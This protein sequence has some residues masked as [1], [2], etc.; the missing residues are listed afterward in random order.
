[1]TEIRVQ[2]VDVPGL[3]ACTVGSDHWEELDRCPLCNNCL[4]STT[5]SSVL[6]PNG[7]GLSL[8]PKMSIC[9]E[10]QF[11]YLSRRPTEKWIDSFYASEWDQ[12]GQNIIPNVP[13][14]LKAY[15]ICK[16]DLGEESRVLEVGAGFGGM[17]LP[18]RDAG[19][20]IAA[21]EPSEH[22]AEHLKS[23]GVEVFK[24]IPTTGDYDL[25]FMH[26]ALEHV[27][28]AQETVRDIS[29][30]LRPGGLFFVAVPSLYQE[31]PIQASHYVPHLS[32]FTQHSLTL[33]L[34]ENGL[35]PLKGSFDMELWCIAQKREGG[36]AE[37]YDEN[38]T[39]RI[40][41]WALQG[42][43]SGPLTVSWTID[44]SEEVRYPSLSMVGH[45]NARGL[46]FKQD[47]L[48][49]LWLDCPEKPELPI[50]YIHENTNPVWVK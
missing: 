12:K 10:C 44:H 29:A 36:K 48:R 6:Q 28:D 45:L 39:D 23:Q 7:G 11:G 37:G 31:H 26:H 43:A 30:A 5:L 4:N 27:Y 2:T 25:V 22:R 1:M 40:G 35:N 46:F 21:V 17:L 42:L 49:T 19:H 15:D 33:L 47:H 13:I 24:D 38:F 34:T 8:G 32:L 9:S 16:G 18:F 14:N 20:S 41:Q 50:T 3:V